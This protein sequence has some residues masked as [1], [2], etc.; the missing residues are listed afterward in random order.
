MGTFHS[1]VLK[2]LPKALRS[3]EI[4]LEKLTDEAAAFMPPHLT[5]ANIEP[6]LPH[7]KMYRNLSLLHD[8]FLPE[9]LHSDVDDK[10]T[11]FLARAVIYPDPR[12][13]ERYSSATSDD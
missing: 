5:H 13:V 6:F 7:S 1:G 4:Q 2:S 11:S 12:T 9:Y 3:L 8:A 10:L